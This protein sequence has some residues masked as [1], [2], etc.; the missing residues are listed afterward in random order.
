M[1]QSV[2]KM[3]S[4]MQ[5]D[6]FL[7]FI[8]KQRSSFFF[9]GSFKDLAA[10]RPGLFSF[11][12]YK[13]L[14]GVVTAQVIP[15]FREN[16]NALTG[17]FKR[18]IDRNTVISEKVQGMGPCIVIQ[19]VNHNGFAR[20]LDQFSHSMGRIFLHKFEAFRKTDVIAAKKAHHQQPAHLGIMEQNFRAIRKNRWIFIGPSRDVNGVSG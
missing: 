4:T 5:T 18:V 6:Q 3:L 13:F 9:T 14:F 1:D 2:V 16:G 19:A 20:V 17:D 8:L 10:S 12:E 11:A 7:G 15:V